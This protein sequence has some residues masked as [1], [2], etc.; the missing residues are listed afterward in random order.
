MWACY[1]LTVNLL[2]ISC[3]ILTCALSG[4]SPGFLFF[5][6]LGHLFSHIQPLWIVSGEYPEFSAWSV[7]EQ[8]YSLRVEPQLLSVHVWCC[9]R[10]KQLTEQKGNLHTEH[11][12][13]QTE[14]LAISGCWWRSWAPLPGHHISCTDRQTCF[15]NRFWPWMGLRRLCV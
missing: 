13:C 2:D 7:W 11:S 9:L 12:P 6:W 14:P 1:L 15:S 10:I 5:N 3:C 4:Q 8:L